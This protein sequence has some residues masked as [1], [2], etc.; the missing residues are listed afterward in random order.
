VFNDLVQWSGP[1][2]TDPDARFH[3]S[4]NTC[5]GCHGPE[6]NTGF[7]MVTAR[8]PGSEATLSPFITGTTVF[9]GFSGQVRTLNDLLRRKTDL[10]GLVCP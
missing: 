6:T 8:F 10:T 3:A 2:I 4:L 7:L 1:G 9:D 5:N